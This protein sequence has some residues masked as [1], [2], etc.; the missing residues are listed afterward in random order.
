MRTNTA[1]RADSLPFDIKDPGLA[2]AGRR[3]IDWAARSLPVLQIIRERFAREQPLARLRI[4]AC[5]HVTCETAAL[6]SWQEGT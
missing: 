6:A 3:R 2:K 4:S 5:M 1:V